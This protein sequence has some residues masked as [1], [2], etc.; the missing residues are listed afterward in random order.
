[1]I[2]LQAAVFVA[3][4]PEH[5]NCWRQRVIWCLIQV[6]GRNVSYTCS[7]EFCIFRSKGQK[8]RKLSS[9]GSIL[10]ITWM[11]LKTAVN[12]DFT[13]NVRGGRNIKTRGWPSM[14]KLPSY[15]WSKSTFP[16]QVEKKLLRGSLSTTKCH[17]YKAWPR[18]LSAISTT[19]N[20]AY[21][22]AKI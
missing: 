13:P 4:Q 22:Y 19:R 8:K 20:V 17:P 3:R 14:W 9:L 11:T 6:I 1:M 7:T 18:N 15:D 21:M 2:L 16:S 5:P 12:F 10:S